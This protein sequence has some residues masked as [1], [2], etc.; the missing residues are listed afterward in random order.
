GVAAQRLGSSG[1]RGRAALRRARIASRRCSRSCDRCAVFAWPPDSWSR[2]THER[3]TLDRVFA[4]KDVLEAL[5]AQL[6]VGTTGPLA[7]C[8]RHALRFA[9]IDGHLMRL[10]GHARQP[11]VRALAYRCL[12]SGQA[13]WIVSVEWMWIDKVYFLRRRVPKL[14]T[15][16][17]GRAEP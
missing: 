2:W 6:R 15:R 7:A 14:G 16:L 17:I 9:D 5:A 4:R 11:S 10:A 13:D 1:S 8:L 12:I 3:D